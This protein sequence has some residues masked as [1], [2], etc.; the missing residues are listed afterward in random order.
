[1]VGERENQ[2]FILLEDAQKILEELEIK[3]LQDYDYQRIKEAVSEKH[4]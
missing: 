2:W 4:Y 3:I 1:M